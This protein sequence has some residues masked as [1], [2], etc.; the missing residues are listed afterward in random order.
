MTYNNNRVACMILSLLGMVD[1]LYLTYV[2]LSQNQTLCIKGLGDCWS[3][4][5]SRYSEVFGIPVAILGAATY[6][7]LLLVLFFESRIKILTQTSS[8]LLFG[9]S[10]FGTI[11][12]FYLTYLE[13][14]VIKAIC[15]FCVASAVIMTLLFIFAI[16]RLFQTQDDNSAL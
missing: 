13:L 10:L 2:K 7:I 5:T 4:N 6:A 8:Y 9:V 12:S 1:S 15:P 16:V 14:A 3:V 11:Y